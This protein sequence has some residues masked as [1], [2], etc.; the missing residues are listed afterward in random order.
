[1]VGSFN[2]LTGFNNTSIPAGDYIWFSS[3]LGF[4]GQNQL[5]DLNGSTITFTNQI[6]DLFGTTIEVPDTTIK[7]GGTSPATADF[8]GGQWVVDLPAQ[9]LKGDQFGDGVAY[10][11]LSNLTHPSPSDKVTWTGDVSSN[12]DLLEHI[13]FSFTANVFTKF[14]T[15]VSQ[16]QITA[17]DTNSHTDDAGNP[18]NFDSYLIKGAKNHTQVFADADQSE[19]N[20]LKLEIVPVPEAPAL[21]MVLLAICG[22]LSLY[23]MRRFRRTAANAS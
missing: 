14:P 1:V 7:I 9:N 8:T 6:I 12:N 21:V 17:T 22:G 3:D 20:N 23:G 16:L 13:Q 11:L 4:P 10:K 15:D 2:A 18:S 19:E 5:K